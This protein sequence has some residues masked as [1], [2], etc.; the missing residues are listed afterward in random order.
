MSKCN[1]ENIYDVNNDSINTSNK[2]GQNLTFHQREKVPER[3]ST[4]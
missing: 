2:K 4:K 1:K 3:R